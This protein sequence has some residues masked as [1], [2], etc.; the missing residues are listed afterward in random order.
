MG[1]PTSKHLW[2]EGHDLHEVALAQLAGDGAEDARPARVSL[3]VDDHGRVLVEGDVGAVLA[4][5]LL[6]RAHHHRRHHLALLDAAVGRRLL[7]RADDDV[8]DAGVAALAA[9]L[10]A[11]AEQ[12]AG[13]GVV[14]HAQ[15]GLHLDHFATST[16]SATRQRLVFESGRVSTSRTT[17][18][19]L[20]L[21]ASSWACSRIE[22]RIIFLYLGCDL[23]MSTRTT[24]V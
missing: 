12:L 11:D 24:T 8:A 2:C 20:A 7:D 23:T 17:S 21:P 22:R 14:G 15:P 3:V 16:I 18:P 6:L 4:V 10:D 5:V 9:A 1:S 13:A 19:S